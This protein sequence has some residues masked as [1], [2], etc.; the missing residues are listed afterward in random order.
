M[1]NGRPP[2]RTSR[3]A[4]NN[5][6][7]RVLILASF[8]NR[9]SNGL[10]NAASVLYCTL[11]VDLPAAQVGAALTVAGAIG[12][13]VGIPG[14]HLADRRGRRTVMVLALAV[15]AAAMSALAL[16][17]T[18]GALAVVAT[19][20]Q[21][22]AA[23]G[24]AAWGALVARVGTDHPALF[25]AKLRT[26]VNLGVVLGTVGAGFAVTAHTRT[27]YVVLIL[28]KRGQLCAV[29]P[30][31]ALAPR[32]QGMGAAFAATP[33][34]SPRRPTVRDLHRPLRRDGTCS[35]RRYPCF[36]RYGSQHTRTR[37]AGPSPRYSRS[38]PDS[39]SSCRPESDP[40]SKPLATAA[41][42][43]AGQDCSSSS[44]ARCWP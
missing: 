27:A 38:M 42:R 13:L 3:I 25:R 20:G 1:V 11:V 34:D 21:L 37:R 36:C 28:G 32:L 17:E 12:L 22:A 35:T 30:P 24:G 31:P 39:A 29:C 26:Y 4:G 7:E 44:A 23:V 40:A 6:P 15:Q 18:W 10:F 41:Q 2:G 43:S 19:V 9:V 33:L 16:V 5:R 14:G 8:V